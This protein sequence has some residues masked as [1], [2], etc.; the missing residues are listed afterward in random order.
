MPHGHIY[1]GPV[2]AMALAITLL[3]VTS[4][5]ATAASAAATARTAIE[6]L[7]SPG[8]HTEIYYGDDT[9]GL[10]R[11]AAP[12]GG[13]ALQTAGHNTSCSKDASSWCSQ[14][15][16]DT[17]WGQQLPLLVPDP[18]G[19]SAGGVCNGETQSHPA[20]PTTPSH[21]VDA[22]L[23]GVV[24]AAIARCQMSWP[25]TTARQGIAPTIATR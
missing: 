6:D 20:M 10:S 9:A 25:R 17:L 3:P 14:Y 13:R 1:V 7:L 11:P 23:I 18:L 2:V 12:G 15:D 4:G 19:G 8:I 24:A 16:V 5:A 22:T 21:T